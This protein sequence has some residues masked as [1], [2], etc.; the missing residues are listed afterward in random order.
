M[1]L[2]IVGRYFFFPYTYLSLFLSLNLRI[3]ATFMYSFLGS[4]FLAVLQPTYSYICRILSDLACL[5]WTFRQPMIRRQFINIARQKV[6]NLQRLLPTK[7]T[8]RSNWYHIIC[9]SNENCLKS[10]RVFEPYIFN[11]IISKSMQLTTL[12]ILGYK[13]C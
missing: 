9:T 8:T 6:C 10:P 7:T 5:L 12:A 1:S 3:F 13:W 4:Y 11:M 2:N